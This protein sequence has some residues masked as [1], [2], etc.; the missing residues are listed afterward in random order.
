MNE[1]EFQDTVVDLAHAH[2]WLVAHF[3]TAKVGD[4]YA[5]AVGYDGA[6]FPDLVLAHPT[7]GVIFAE[8]K[9]RTGKMA[10]RQKVWTDT[11]WRAGADVFIW[12]PDDLDD[13]AQVLARGLPGRQGG[14][15][16]Q[17][18]GC[19][20]PVRVSPV[21]PYAPVPWCSDECAPVDL[22][23]DGDRLRERR[24]GL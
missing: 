3:R 13:I 6:G 1:A 16:D 19:G 21:D 12:R 14:V 18:P 23:D 24:E 20:D 8:L 5:T 11:L 10:P 7:K 2:K 22:F 9:S 4:R 15:F 17:C